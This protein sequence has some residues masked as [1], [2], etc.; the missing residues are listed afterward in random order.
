MY[1]QASE[2]L[3]I[4][5]WPDDPAPMELENALTKALR[6]KQICGTTAAFSEEDC[7][8][9]LDYATEMAKVFTRQDEWGEGGKP[10]VI[11][12]QFISVMNAM[13][14]R[15]TAA[16]V[17]SMVMNGQTVP[18]EQRSEFVKIWEAQKPAHGSD[19]WPS[20]CWCRPEHDRRQQGDLPRQAV[21]AEAQ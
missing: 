10:I 21:G 4:S 15:L 11:F 13:S 9:K 14:D 6:L 7:S 8:F 2:E 5:R 16:G 12:S 19:R 1:K 3:Q 17:P 18:K 20:S